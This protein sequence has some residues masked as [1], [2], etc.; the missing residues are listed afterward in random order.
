LN[1][2]S[3]EI[4]AERRFGVLE[5][6][7]DKRLQHAEHTIEERRRRR[8]D[9]CGLR[10]VG[11]DPSRTNCVA[12]LLLDRMT[13]RIEI[14]DLLIRDV[15]ASIR[16]SLKH[17]FACTDVRIGREAGTEQQPDELQ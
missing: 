16:R 1:F 17:R 7:V 12:D 15:D 3:L 9:A 10:R 6:R 14:E 5:Q 13:R 11:L 8:E 4:V 2:S